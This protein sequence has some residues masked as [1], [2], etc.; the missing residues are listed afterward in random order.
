M[1]HPYATFI[2]TFHR[3]FR[4]QSHYAQDHPQARHAMDALE[5]H[6]QE[7]LGASHSLQLRAEGDRLFLDGQAA[8]GAPN[9]SQVLACTLRDRGIQSLL[10]HGAPSL[11]DLQLLFFVLNLQ[12]QRLR[13]LGGAEL[14][15]EDAEVIQ[16]HMGAGLAQ[17][18]PRPL[19]QAPTSPRALSEDLQGLLGAVVQMTAAPLRPDPRSPWTMEQRQALA[20]FEFQLADLS[21]MDG[22][23]AQLGLEGY[24]PTALRHALRSA[25]AALPPSLQG[26][27]LMGMPDF[28][29]GE[30]ALRRALDYL[31]PELFAQSL[32]AAELQRGGSL[33]TLALAAAALLHCVK[34][35]ELAMEA[36]KGRFLLEGWTLE[37][38]DALEEAVTWECHGTDTKL[39]LCLLD[40]SI[41]ELNGQQLSILV[42]Q[43][44]RGRRA[45]GLR[46]LLSQLESGFASPQ[47]ARRQLT[48]T[49]LSDL[50]DCLLDP[51]LP[52]DLEGRMLALLH[53]HI[54]SEED[55]VAVRWSCQALE[56]LLLHWMQALNFSAVY[57]EMLA[58]GE[59]TLPHSGAP[60]WKAQTVRDVLSRLASPPSLAFL[61]PLIHAQ[62]AQLS[63]PQLHALLTLLGRP[64]AQYLVV[65]LEIEADRT[66][67]VHLLACLRAIGRNAVPALV[68]ALA[69]PAWYLAR[70]ALDLLTEI[71]HKPAFPHV[72]L[73]LEHPDPR[74][75][76]AAL[77]ATSALGS[78]Q[79]V[80]EALL[81]ALPDGG[82]DTQLQILSVLG[83][84]GPE[85][86]DAAPSLMNLLASLKGTT[87]EVVRVRLRILEVIG[88]LKGNEALP[89]LLDVFRKK[90]FLA[91]REG[92]AVRIAAVKALEAIGTRESRE[93]L[94]L[95]MDLESDVEIRNS[96]RQILVNG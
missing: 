30:T 53:P 24:D 2:E 91:S 58:L 75:R 5:A 34:D 49:V 61:V 76:K 7:F 16:V 56:S 96:I 38:T 83:D 50:A 13:E 22:T 95:A 32:A 60:E 94:A 85:A 71:G 31:A 19:A 9:A 42:R 65:C 68:D 89:G 47:P 66:R 10:F 84:L 78:P 12:P 90:G 43:L 11:D 4:A 67:R 63:L 54:A 36:L 77:R 41:Y 80:L 93:T 1:S 14:L 73:A 17:G 6:F 3:A 37:Q 35:R 79:Q 21:G 72:A 55:P 57:T 69:S 29:T 18:E 46:D 15:L 28:P 70:N 92:S 82:V 86:R 44:A 8:Q 74:V 59:L 48:A 20:D 25:V 88:R 45:D 27:L 64:A 81:P 23:G 52:A 87:G 33:Y 26:A 40:R 39:R 62:E 51:G